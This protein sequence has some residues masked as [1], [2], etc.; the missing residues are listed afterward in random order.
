MTRVLIAG[1]GVAGVEAMLALSHLEPEGVDVELLSPSDRFVYRPLQV[2]E[3]FGSG[4]GA[5]EMDLE[6]MV[7]DAGARHVA[8]G[9]ESVDAVEGTVRTTS[10]RAREY[11]ALLVAI[12]AQP[13]EAVR[14]ALTFGI[15]DG[16][17]R[18]TVMLGSLGHRGSTRIAYVVPGG[19]TWSIAAYELAL[20]TAAERDARRLE[21]VEIMLVTY[22]WDP[23]EVFGTAASE[24]VTERLADAGIEFRPASVARS[25]EQ[26][27]LILANGE[28]IELDHAVA[29][30]GLKVPPIRGLPQ[31]ED[32]FV[33][34]DARMRVDGL[35]NVWAAG[36]VTPFP[37]KQG[38]LAAQQADAAAKGI[39]AAAGAS[40]APEPF[41]PILRATLVTGDAPDF[42]RADPDG[43]GAASP[44]V[45]LWAPTGKVAGRYLA[46]YLA[47]QGSGPDELM[48]VEPTDAENERAAHSRAVE[49]ILAAA[50]ADAELERFDDAIR[51]LSLV[52]ELNLVVPPEYVARRHEW[53]RQVDPAAPV[54]PAAKRIDPS[55]GSAA[56]ALSDLQRRIGWLREIE[57]RHEGEMRAQL[58]AADAGLAELRALSNRTGVLR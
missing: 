2:V 18:L 58:A 29:L 23:L 37:I 11:D 3:P 53:R 51:W 8:D 32:G 38:G 19:A 25:F 42:L 57:R 6:Q 24:L 1:G 41:A 31:G 35:E 28:P 12:G 48:D 43:D 10:G 49:L 50:D 45:A 21:G 30:P 9:L 55:F 16:A 17:A 54:D 13:I 34:T 26:G 40:A 44:G 20:L 15:A 22:E 5:V 56:E 4:E 14:G 47:G 36:D 33:R 7:S 52:E 46:P 39:A 27:R